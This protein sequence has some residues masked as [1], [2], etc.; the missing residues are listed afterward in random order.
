MLSLN[1]W[2]FR[3]AKRA[4]RILMSSIAL[5]YRARPSEISRFRLLSQSTF[6]NKGEA[7]AGKPPLEVIVRGRSM[8]EVGEGLVGLGH[9][10]DV[11]A[12]GHRV[13]FAAV[14]GQQL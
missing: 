12:L 9:A 4:H 1:S 14:G 11:F 10:V 8:G 3:G 6:K 13:A 2:E 5:R 7:S